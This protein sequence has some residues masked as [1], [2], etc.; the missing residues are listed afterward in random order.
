MVEDN[1]VRNVIGTHVTMGEENGRH[2][3]GPVPAERECAGRHFRVKAIP[4]GGAT[5]TTFVCLR[6]GRE[7]EGVHQPGN[8]S[9]LIRTGADIP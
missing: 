4:V 5:S 8:N 9:S 6:C 3:M 1:T 7:L 2:F